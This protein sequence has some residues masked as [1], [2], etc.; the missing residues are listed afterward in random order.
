MGL[1]DRDYMRDRYRQRQG[2]KRDVPLGSASWIGQAAQPAAS[3]GAWFDRKNRGHTYQQGRSRGRRP[4][5]LS[6]A[7]WLIPILCLSTYLVPM[8]FDAKRGGWMPD[9]KPGIEFPE[10]GSVTVASNLPRKR[11]TSRLSVQTSDA[12]AVVQLF[13]PRLKTLEQLTRVPIL[14]GNELEA[15]RN[16]LA[17]L[18]ESNGQRIS[19]TVWSEVFTCPD[20]TG[21]IN[22]HRDAKGDDEG[23]VSAK[24]PCPHCAA[25]LNKDRLER[26]FESTADPA[27]GE[28]WRRVKFE[29]VLAAV[30]TASGRVERELT[31]EDHALL[32]RIEALSLPVDVATCRSTSARVGASARAHR[33]PGRQLPPRGTEQAPGSASTG[34]AMARSGSGGRGAY[35]SNRLS[36]SMAK[37]GRNSE[38]TR[39][40]A[41][42]HDQREWLTAALPRQFELPARAAHSRHG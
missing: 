5:V 10:S 34:S 1:D 35:R 4:S 26:V 28:I 36:L 7:R 30:A 41:S 32:A 29:P 18:Y 39:L 11:I 9:L 37:C 6:H 22:F 16:T 31:A 17:D 23:R 14:P 15:F 8:Y 25:E 3:G 40:I 21:T 42:L 2:A 12:N 20:C 38:T 24:F 27:T 19:Y 13:D 33:A